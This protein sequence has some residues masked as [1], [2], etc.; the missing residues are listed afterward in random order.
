MRTDISFSTHL[1][2]QLAK[3]GIG[4]PEIWVMSKCSLEIV[5]GD[6]LAMLQFCYCPQQ[7]IDV[8]HIR[9]N[10][11]TILEFWPQERLQ[12]HF[13]L[14]VLI[15]LDAGCSKE[16]GGLV[17]VIVCSNEQ[18]VNSVVSPLFKEVRS[19]VKGRMKQGVQKIAVKRCGIGEMMDARRMEEREQVLEVGHLLLLRW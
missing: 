13:S 10:S 6:S 15:E 3:M 18:T 2:T 4:F 5:N 12:R 19:V 9:H 14:D 8:T 11:M 7:T 16:E 1:H 17:L